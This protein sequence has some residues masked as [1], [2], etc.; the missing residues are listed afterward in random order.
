MLNR[1]PVG[2]IVIIS[3][4]TLKIEASLHLFQLILALHLYHSRQFL[5]FLVLG[6][7]TGLIFRREIRIGQYVLSYDGFTN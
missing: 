5:P 1:H 7:S 3:D 6:L 4:N 2:L